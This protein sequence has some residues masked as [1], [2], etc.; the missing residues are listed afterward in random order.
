KLVQAP[1]LGMEHQSAVAYGNKF[2]D[3]YMGTD[4][5]GT[6]WGLKWDFIIIHESAHEWWGNS[7]TT[8]DVADM[9]VHEGFANYAEALYTECLDGREAGAEYVRGVRHRILNDRPV[10]GEYGVNYEGSGDMYYKG[11]NVVQ[12][13]RQ[14]MNDDSAFR[15]LLH[16]LQ[17]NFFHQTVT[18]QQIEDYIIAQSGIDLDDL[19]DQYLRETNVPVLKYYIKK[20]R[21]HF[22]WTNVFPHFDMPVKVRLTEDDWSLIKPVSD[23]WKAVKIDLESPEHFEVNKNY[24]IRTKRVEK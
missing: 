21:L 4:L 20:N 18:S 8:K 22:K 7:I 16:G 17:K 11:G 23:H 10:I 5:S 1:Y 15:A 2:E 6:G 9:W 19:F 13:I 3:G 12:M 14:N 24:Y